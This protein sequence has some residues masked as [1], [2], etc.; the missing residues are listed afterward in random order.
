MR[1]KRLANKG[2]MREPASDFFPCSTITRTD[3][4]ASNTKQMAKEC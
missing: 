3:T 4:K 2:G 1:V